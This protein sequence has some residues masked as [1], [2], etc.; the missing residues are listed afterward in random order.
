[1]EDL[2]RLNLIVGLI[3][4]CIVIT[5]TFYSVLRR[6]GAV[7]KFIWRLTYRIIN[8]A[9]QVYVS[10]CYG[11]ADWWNSWGSRFT[12]TLVVIVTLAGGI[13]YAAT[14]LNLLNRMPSSLHSQAQAYNS[15]TP[16]PE[17]D[18]GTGQWTVDNHIQLTCLTD[19]VGLTYSGDGS[20]FYEVYFAGSDSAH[21]L[22]ANK[23]S[24]HLM[25]TFPE[26]S[27]AYVGIGIHG[28][29]NKGICGQMGFMRA[30]GT[31]SLYRYR[32]DGTEDTVLDS[33]F[34]PSG[35]SLYTLD[36]AVE[37]SSI[38]LV[39]NGVVLTNLTD[40]TFQTTSYVCIGVGG[41]MNDT[42]TISNFEFTPLSAAE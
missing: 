24:V 23:Y 38:S 20:D 29:A 1:M 16:G 5:G 10:L 8:V 9:G 3:A 33:G 18:K 19:R 6:E 14:R 42:V 11:F 41:S 21:K 39:V 34:A 37:G 32:A 17:C 28:I 31:W 26:D 30:D 22:F 4:G 15:Q 40:S 13:L 7:W 27:D 12:I 36:I 35:T 2:T 25:V